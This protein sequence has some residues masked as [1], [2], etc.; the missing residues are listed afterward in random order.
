M[1]RKLSEEGTR[2]HLQLTHLLDSRNEQHCKEITLQLKQRVVGW[3]FSVGYIQYEDYLQAE[4]LGNGRPHLLV[5][6]SQGS[7]FVS[8]SCPQLPK[9]VISYI[10]PILLF[11]FF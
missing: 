8:T 4:N 10:L 3:D 2:V 6:F 1:G 11:F 5:L 9:L 7:Q